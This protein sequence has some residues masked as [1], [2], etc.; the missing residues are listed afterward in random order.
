MLA[1]KHELQNNG[2]HTCL[3]LT[4]KTQKLECKRAPYIC[5]IDLHTDLTSSIA[6]SRVSPNS[7]Q[8]LTNRL[9]LKEVLFIIQTIT[10]F[11]LNQNR[12]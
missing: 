8:K 4:Q 6:V 10:S 11:V 7:S 2:L 9:F 3:A 1:D 12:S 5:K